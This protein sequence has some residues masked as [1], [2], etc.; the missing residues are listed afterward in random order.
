MF[1]LDHVHHPVIVYSSAHCDQWK[2]SGR[3]FGGPSTN[4][5]I[6][7]VTTSRMTPHID[8]YWCSEVTAKEFIK[9]PFTHIYSC[10]KSYEQFMY[11]RDTTWKAW[12]Q[13]CYE[14]KCIRKKILS[15]LSESI[16]HLKPHIFS[17]FLYHEIWI[18]IGCANH[19]QYTENGR[20]DI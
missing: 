8:K 12:C 5:E 11:K 13:F 10:L 18:D 17:S 19:Q 7:W 15:K 1:T 3:P 9:K 20:C 4:R 2:Q 14:S 6:T 16:M